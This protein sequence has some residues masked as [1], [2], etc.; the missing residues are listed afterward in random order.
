MFTRPPRARAHARRAGP[1]QGRPLRPADEPRARRARGLRRA[2]GRLPRRGDRDAGR[3]AGPRARHGRGQPRAQHAERRRGSTRALASLDFMVSVDIYLN[4]T[5][6][7]AHVIL[8]GA[9]AA[10]AVAL[11]RRAPPARD[12]QRRELLAAGVRA[13][14][15]PAA[16]VGDAAAARRRSWRARAPTPTR[17]ARRLRRSGSSS[18]TRSRR[19]GSPVARA[20]P[21]R[22]P[23]RARR[24]AAAP[25]ALLDL[26]LRTGPYGDGFGAEP[27]RPHA[28]RPRGAPARRRPRPA[29][30]APP[31]GAAHADGED[32]ARARADRRRRRAPARRPRAPGRRRWCSSAAA[33]SARTTRGC[34]TSRVLVKGEAALHGAAC[35]PTTRRGSASPTAAL[36]R[37]RSRAGAIEVP[38]EV[39]D[40]IMPGVV[41]IPHGWGHDAP[42]TR[43]PRRARRTPASNSNLLADELRDSI[44]SPGT[45]S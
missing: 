19:P 27:G 14:A 40:A 42:G 44:R 34:T 43:A 9:L 41:S 22:D 12:P 16:G 24:R 6:R 45:R 8:P 5:T 25:S 23:R 26:M 21:R 35:I 2:P 10:R 20:R 18:S 37:V 33:T 11:R 13:A 39:T 15:G 38:V 31:R 1:R 32:R 3:R 4:E 29:R 28:R 7:H 36:A 17:R 30:A